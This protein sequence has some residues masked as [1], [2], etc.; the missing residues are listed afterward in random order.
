M[1][2][3]RK[4]CEK[5]IFKNLQKVYKEIEIWEQKTDEKIQKI[6]KK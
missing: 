5:L 4:T 2:S 3:L 1:K 6:A